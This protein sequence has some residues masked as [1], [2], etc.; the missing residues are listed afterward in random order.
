M[1]GYTVIFSA[2]D[3]EVKPRLKSLKYADTIENQAD[4]LEIVLADNEHQLLS[5]WLPARGVEM[6]V[7]LMQDETRQTLRLGTFEVDE[8][9]YKYP[10]SEVTIKFN[11]I[12]AR[13]ELRGIERN[14]SWEETN[15]QRIARDIAARA[16]LALYYDAPQVEIKRAEQCGEPDLQFLLKLCKN[17]GLNLKIHDKQ[18]VVFEALRYES[19]GAVTTVNYN[20]KDILSFNARAKSTAIY[21]DAQVS[22]KSNNVAQ[23]LW[24]FFGGMDL[25]KS[26]AK[27]AATGAGV[28]NINQKVNSEGEAELLARSKLREQNKSE[29]TL[30]LTLMG[31]FNFLAGNVFTL[32]GHGIFDGNYICDKTTH[33]IGENGYTVNIS[34]HKCLKY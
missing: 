17:A 11:S 28:L 22:Y 6:A 3:S 13:S 20:A 25:F 26:V 1:R 31:N 8:L 34:A 5:N 33:S 7:S 27:V 21:A 2:G 4:T 30:T 23:W 18:L 10:P 12:P 32:S 14:Q 9:N 15:L 16:G 19:K 24:S 29:W